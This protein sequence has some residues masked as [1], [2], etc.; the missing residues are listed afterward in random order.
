MEVLPAGHT[1]K[2]VFALDCCF[3]HSS[4]VHFP[5]KL[6]DGYA[7]LKAHKPFNNNTGICGDFHLA[8]GCG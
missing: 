5:S 4:W 7:R 6:P 1:E 3:L 8:T 2:G